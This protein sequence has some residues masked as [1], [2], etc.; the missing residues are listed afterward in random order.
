MFSPSDT[1][2]ALAT[3]PAPA[4]IGVVRLSG[5]RAVA[6]ARG[7][8]ALGRDLEPRRAT[9]T[10]VVAPGA[11]ESSTAAIPKADVDAGAGRPESGNRPRRIDEVVVTFFPAPHS[12][13]V[14]DVVEI[15]AH[16]SL[17]LLREIVAAAMAGGARLAEPGE[18]TLR[19]FLNGRLDLV[20]AEAVGDLVNA[21]TPLQARVAFDQLEG[22]LTR[23]I[24]ALDAQLFGL[25]AK[26]EASVD[27]PDEGYHFMAA[28]EVEATLVG[29]RDAVARLL[30]TAARGRL[31]REGRHIAILGRPNVG[32]SSLFNALVGTDRAIVTAIP[33]TT[34]DLLRET[35][36]FEGVRLGLVDTAGIRHTDDEVEREGVAR[37]RGAG[38]VADVVLLMLDRSRPLVGEDLAL[39]GETAGWARIVIVNK[40]DLA[41]AWDIRDL[42][43]V[44]P[45]ASRA[46][47]VLVSL[48]TGAGMEALRR[49]LREALGLR[50][51]TDP[52]GDDGT[53][54]AGVR[55]DPPVV[56][57]LRHAALLAE[58]RASL[59]RA[60][61]NLRAAGAHA[62]E[63]LVIADLAEARGAFEAVTGR[64][65]SE[66]VL[67]H[68]FAN[69]CIGK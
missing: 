46:G 15:S 68:I 58:A 10:H 63:E 32:K 16:G 24:G 54:G 65:S 17:E 11:P 8:I 12:Y 42:P 22:T 66:D 62:S 53:P 25:A 37:A 19:A 31:I 9:L 45:G 55:R 43:G 3:A 13:T 5:P 44:G 29:V 26:L 56:S 18:F 6:I 61:G 21:V 23:A 40:I 7:M 28:G 35:I 14:E 67:R 34:R 41:P 20:Q 47:L 52:R 59:D 39:L 69:F 2:V 4:G 30:A 49:A 27:F 48:K 57:N 51:G 36:D 33:G 60:I 50:G 1:I 64:R 38:G